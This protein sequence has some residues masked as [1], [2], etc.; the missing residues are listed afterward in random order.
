MG[1]RHVQAAQSLG[2]E[3]AGICDLNADMLAQTEREHSVSADRHFGNLGTMLAAT[4]PDCL[5]IATT[6]PTHAEFTCAAAETGVKHVLCEKPMAVSLEQCDHMIDVCRAHG[7]ALA[8]NHQMR[9]MEQYIEPKRIA[10]SEA[11]GG[12]RSV[13]VSAGNFGLSM[14]ALHYF[15]MFR[16]MTDETP[17][18]VTA[19]FSKETVPNP[20]GAQ[21]QDRAGTVR[22]VTESGRRFYL[23]C[24]ADQGHGMYVVYGGPYGQMA[25]DELYGDMALAVREAPHRALPTTRYG[26]PAVRTRTTIEPAS[27]IGPSAA[28]LQ[29]LLDRNNY[30]NGEDGRLAVSVL[31]AAYQSAEHGN[32]TVDL[33]TDQLDRGRM[34][35]WA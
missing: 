21:F 14:N 35:P 7:T 16:F 4:A 2:L 19:W 31:V 29:A 17:R 15:E 28:V 12:L 5:I 10:Q 33:A 18:Y 23:D 34:F 22:I 24:S 26:M 30:P 27:V 3:V 6:A 32:R 11:F 8:I 20:R 25:V 9:F 13:T 1:R